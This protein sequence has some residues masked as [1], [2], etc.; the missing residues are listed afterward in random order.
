MH[1]EE[2]LQWIHSIARFGSNLGLSRIRALL[3]SLGD[4]HAGLRFVHI[5][6][7]NGKG[8]TAAFTA[9]IL[10]EAG[11]RVGLYTSPYLKSFANRISVNGSDISR[12]HLTYFVELIRPLVDEIAADPA[13]G[14]PTEFEVVTALAMAY[15]AEVKPDIIVLEVGL[16][17][18][19][20][21]TNVVTPLVTLITTVSLDHMD[22]LGN[23]VEEIAFEKAGIIKGQAPVITGVTTEEAL[24]VL[25]QRS[26]EC[27]APLYRFG[28]DFCYAG[29]R[30]CSLKGQYFNY[31]SLSCCYENLFIS[32]LGEHQL[33]NAA[34]AVAASEVL[35][36]QGFVIPETS[37]RGGLEKTLWPGRL[38]ILN[39][40][41]LV[42]IDGAHNIE[43]IRALVHSVRNL[44]AYHRLVI[45]LGI[46]KDKEV[47]EMLEAIVPLA[48]EL[49]ITTPPS[50]RASDP[51][52]I[53]KLSL[54]LA[55]GPVTVKQSVSDA[56]STA[57]K[58]AGSSDMVL[59][60]GSLY[61]IS[62]A[63]ELLIDILD[64]RQ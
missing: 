52:E 15:F 29:R 38:E 37:V 34:M 3:K 49:I 41:P 27:G 5:G 1:Y 6:G 61:T 45:V 63:R 9:S 35:N 46:L 20:D 7:T 22:V 10:Q 43:A 54:P 8:S 23:S 47:E 18:R 19:L 36:R 53:R 57:L 21:A 39:Y 50:P 11:Y 14:Q 55:R 42:V 40:A 62:R 28:A 44:F 30:S 17:G 33:L 59:V 25:S 58:R 60:A 32:L 56:V 13:L 26:E 2:A 48:D 4:P 16:G 31:K 12:D 24:T 51:R 64:A